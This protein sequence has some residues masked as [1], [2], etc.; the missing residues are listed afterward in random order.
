MLRHPL[1]QTE[2][3]GVQAKANADMAKVVS[4]SGIWDV[5]TPRGYLAMLNY[6]HVWVWVCMHLTYAR[7]MFHLH[8]KLYSKPLAIVLIDF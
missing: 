5:Y 8:S 7:Q 2:T 3:H 6:I 1:G 4:V